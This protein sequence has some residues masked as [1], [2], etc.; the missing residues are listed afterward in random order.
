MIDI[1]IH[2]RFSHDSKELPENYINAANERKI[3]VI[4]FSEHYD[5]DAI[6]DN[7]QNVWL[8]DIASYYSYYKKLKEQ[9]KTPDILFGIEFGYRDNATFEYKR[10]T[11]DYPFDY[12]INSVHTLPNR[13]DS[14]Y[15]SFFAGRSIHQSYLDYFNAVLDSVKADYDYQIIGH[16]G[17]VSR[18]CK[19]ENTKINYVDYSEIFDEIL[20]EIIKRDKCLELNT[21]TRDAGSDFLPDK[22]VVERY[23]ELGGNKL[24]FAGDAHRAE[25]YL[26]SE[27][28]V[29][30]FLKSI[31]IKK[32]C[33]Y[34]QR[35]CVYY[36]I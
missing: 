16:I 33:Y 24:S 28:K 27:Q 31:G 13:G 30:E 1:H 8:C 20:K 35:K 3:P 15:P 17:Y 29:E 4:G 11:K 34:K 2:T 12:I 7:D 26:R 10:L 5:Y 23:L 25:D 22:D 9:F 32:M 19:G 21:S 6:L 36:D 18:Y 14:F